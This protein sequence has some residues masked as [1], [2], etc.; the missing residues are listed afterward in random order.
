MRILGES[1]MKSTLLSSILI[2]ILLLIM[3]LISS[4]PKDKYTILVFILGRQ[5]WMSVQI[6]VLFIANLIMGFIISWII[7]TCICYH[8]F[9]TSK[10][11]LQ[12]IFDIQLVTVILLEEIIWRTI[13]FNAF[14]ELLKIDTW[15][16]TVVL[17][18][19]LSILFVRAHRGRTIEMYLYTLLLFWG[20]LC[21]PG[22]N[23]GMHWGRNVF[24]K[25][26][27]KKI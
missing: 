7:M 26:A 22:S 1:L 13:A 14:K 4:A 10:L 9:N 15:Q 12:G 16:L 19:S 11:S 25:E 17:I 8:F 2:C 18:I 24:L 27:K 23:I 21:L 6:N 3:A 5:Y 20:N